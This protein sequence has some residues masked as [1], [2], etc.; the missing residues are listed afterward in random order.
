MQTTMIIFERSVEYLKEQARKHKRQNGI[1][2]TQAL[3]EVG[4]E[5]GLSPVTEVTPRS[6]CDFAE[7]LPGDIQTGHCASLGAP[8]WLLVALGLL[9]RRRRHA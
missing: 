6:E 2:H 5:S 4:N 9:G 1:S 7:C 3:D 8:P